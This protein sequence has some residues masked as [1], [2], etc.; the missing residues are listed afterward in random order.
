MKTQLTAADCV[1]ECVCWTDLPF[2]ALLARKLWYFLAS[3][4]S[5][6]DK[7]T[8]LQRDSAK[9]KHATRVFYLKA[10]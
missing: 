8:T 5:E 3:R 4:E 10:A 6:T 7:T 2:L 9:D 1:C